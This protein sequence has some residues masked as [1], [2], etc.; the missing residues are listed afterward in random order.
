MN[1][2]IIDEATFELPELC[3][4]EEMALVEKTLS[5][6]PGIESARPDYV[7]RTL[8]VAFDSACVGRSAIVG[9]IEGAGFS[10]TLP[11][12]VDPD[13]SKPS[14]RWRATTALGGILLATAAGLWVLLGETSALVVA[15][16]IVSTLV[17]GVPV[18]RAALRAIRLRALDMNVLMSLAAVGATA[19]GEYFEAATAMFLFAVSLW[20][21]SYGTDR[22]RSAVRS[23]VALS[24]T[25]AHR[26]EARQVRDVDPA[27]LAVGDAILVRP[28]ERLPVDGLVLQ[29]HSA[30]NEA[31]ITGESIPVDKS[32]GE[33]VFAGSLNGEGSLRIETQRTSE[34]STLAHIARLVAEAESR[35][36]PTERFIDRF[37][38][39]YTPVVIGLALLLAF[40][41]PLL[42]RLGANWAVET[43]ATEWFRRGLVLLVIACPCALV[44]STPVTIVCGL[45]QAARRGI[46]IKGGEH[47]ENAGRI[48]AMAFDKTGTLTVG[49]PRVVSVEA[50]PDSPTPS[51]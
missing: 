3:C 40:G 32:P 14:W 6:L 48:D 16:L 42:G 15:L 1:D 12:T 25:V 10:V 24:P 44:I 7:N 46:L 19:I 9:A 17:S 8:R 41:P 29:G 50:R 2:R 45:F 21:E 26:I 39:R 23:L 22:A 51:I 43:A 36:A 13:R 35:R 38:R 49:S 18:L 28:G 47:L 33:P 30:V 27:V 5:R 31:P 34:S 20:L 37:A 4:S 11:G